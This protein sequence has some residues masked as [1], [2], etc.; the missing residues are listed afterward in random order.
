MSQI[1]WDA[2]RWMGECLGVD[3]DDLR[4]GVGMDLDAA[5]Y[6]PHTAESAANDD[7]RSE[8]PAAPLSRRDV[9]PRP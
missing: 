5:P 8:E 3:A 1:L 2:A 7:R 9:T 6:D 4:I